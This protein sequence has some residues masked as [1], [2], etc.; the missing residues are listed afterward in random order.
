VEKSFYEYHLYAPGSTLKD[1]QTKQLN[2]LQKR[3]IKAERRYVYDVALDTRRAAVELV[4]K[5]EKE[6]N[7]GV[8]L[9]RGQVSLQQRD[10][11]GRQPSRS[12]LSITR[13]QGRADAPER[14]AFDVVGQFREVEPQHYEMKMR[15]TKR[16]RSGRGR[17]M[18][19]PFK[20]AN[21]SQPFI[22]HDFQTYW[23]DFTLKPNE[24]H[25]VT[26]SI[27]MP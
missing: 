6:N 5:N 22:R 26:Y 25:T 7:L 24:E 15:A 16:T 19:L 12:S 17:R 2:L 21:S 14:M 8:P 27:D 10:L 9:P 20:I 4:V 3:G 13:G 1:R 18:L 11:D 23:F